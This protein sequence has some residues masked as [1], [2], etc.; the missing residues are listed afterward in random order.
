MKCAKTTDY[1]VFSTRHIQILFRALSAP[2]EPSVLTTPLDS[3]GITYIL[4]W[5]WVLALSE[6]SSLPVDSIT[7]DANKNFTSEDKIQQHRKEIQRK[8]EEML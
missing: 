2:L 6:N 3:V 8:R 4:L 5:Q 1:Y 7:K